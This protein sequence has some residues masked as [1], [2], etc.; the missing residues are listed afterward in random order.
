MLCPKTDDFRDF[1]TFATFATFTTFGTFETLG[2]LRGD[3]TKKR[4]KIDQKIDQKLIF[5]HFTSKIM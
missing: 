3:T 1:W 2:A 5:H 4:A